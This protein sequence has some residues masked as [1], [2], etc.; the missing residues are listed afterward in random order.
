[1]S[2]SVAVL[3]YGFGNVR[4]ALRA[5]DHVGATAILSSDF[6]TC[7]N[8]DGLIIPGVGAFAACMAGIDKVR[9]SALVDARMVARR[10]V[11]GI[12]VGMQI[13]FERGIEHGVTT[14]G[15]GQWPGTV[16]H[17]VAPIVPHMGWNNVAPPASSSL[18]AGVESEMFYFVHS[19]A[20]QQ[21]TM[22]D[23]DPFQHPP[24]LTWCDYGA[25]FIAA[26]ENGPLSAVQFH[27]EKSGEA[28]LTLINN[29]VGTLT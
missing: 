21:W 2:P 20:A 29:W 25:P 23:T 28:G 14:Q 10:P 8:A 15:L 9:G 17:L 13:M 19:Y 18:F 6:D 27:P 12:C 5:A 24:I 3:D 26:V 16:D 22:S 4:S 11:L 1:M 7:L